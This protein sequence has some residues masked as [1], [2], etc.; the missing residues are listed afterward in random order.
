MWDLEIVSVVDIL[1][2][3]SGNL[4]IVYFPLYVYCVVGW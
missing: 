4:L 2:Y 1:F 3:A